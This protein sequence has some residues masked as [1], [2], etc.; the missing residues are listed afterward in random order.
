MQIA[1]FR[2]WC[3]LTKR[4]CLCLLVLCSYVFCNCTSVIAQDVNEAQIK[5]VF[6]YNLTHFVTW[7]EGVLESEPT[8]NIG[9]I[10]D[11]TFQSTLD[12]TVEAETKEDKHFVVGEIT[13]ASDI[14]H[15]CRILFVSGG[16]SENWTEMREKVADLPILTVSDQRDFTRRGG[17]V[18]LIRHNKKIRIEVNYKAVQQA[19]LNMSAK[20]LRLA[21]IVE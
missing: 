2:Y 15:R 9:I 13:K 7:P 21:H 12:T 10:G 19:G 5:A 16:A 3:G 11:E 8:F 14:T 17:M 1:S 18:S 6:L 20:L 4:C